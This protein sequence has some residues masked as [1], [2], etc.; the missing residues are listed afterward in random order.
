M[1]FLADAITSVLLFPVPLLE[2]SW[3]S[4]ADKPSAVQKL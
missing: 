4:T 2:T 1:V 3:L